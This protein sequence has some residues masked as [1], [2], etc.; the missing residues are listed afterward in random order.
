M[1]AFWIL[2][3]LVA[4]L[5]IAVAGWSLSG[6]IS[7]GGHEALRVLLVGLVVGTT[8]DGAFRV[9]RQRLVPGREEDARSWP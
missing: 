1:K 7:G 2:T 8:A 4:V 5:S 6:Q 3:A 9:V